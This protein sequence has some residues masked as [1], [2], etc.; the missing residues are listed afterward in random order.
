[1]YPFLFNRGQLEY[2]LT[3]NLLKHIEILL[4]M[5]GKQVHITKQTLACVLPLLQILEKKWEY[6]GTV[7]QLLIDFKKAYDSVRRNALYNNIL[8]Q[9]GIP[10][11]LVG[12]IK[13][14]LN[15]TYS[16]VRTG[17]NLTSLLFRMA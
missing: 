4:R 5:L 9:F 7:Q 14:C 11:K 17:K 3:N 13:M 8:I 2:R 10:S 16:T 15:E 12:L 1:M 6:N